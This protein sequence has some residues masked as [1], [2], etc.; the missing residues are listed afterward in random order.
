MLIDKIIE[1]FA[2]K[3]AADR[4]VAREALSNYR[5][6]RFD[7]I[8][9]DVPDF[10]GAAGDWFSESSQDRRRIT[11]RARKLVRRSTLAEHL[12]TSSQNNVIGCG[13]TLQSRS[14]SLTWRDDIEGQW[15]E[16]FDRE[17]DSRGM[18]NGVQIL[19]FV[20]GGFLRDGDIG[21]YL[22]P[23]GTIRLVESD[24][25]ATPTGSTFWHKNKVDGID[26]DDDGRPVRYFV[27]KYS[28]EVTGDRRH[29]SEILEIPA[30]QMLFLA[31]RPRPSNTRGISAYA[32]VAHLLS[33]IEGQVEAITAAARMAA[34]FGLVITREGRFGA[35]AANAGKRPKVNLRPGNFL[36]LFPGES[37]TQ[38]TPH[39][40]STNYSEFLKLLV[41]LV[42][43]PFGL[44]LEIALSDFS[45]TNYSN[46][47]ASMLQA[48]HG[49]TILQDLLRD[50]CTALFYW[51][52]GEW[53]RRGR[54]TR[55]RKRIPKDY[56]EH[57]WMAPRWAWLAPEKEI[58]AAQS[59]IDAGFDTITDVC[60]RL[61]RDVDDIVEIRKREI[62]AFEK[63]GVP[64]MHSTLTRDAIDPADAAEK[65]GD[66]GKEEE[67]VTEKQMNEALEKFRQ[68]IREDM[69]HAAPQVP[70]SINV[71]LPESLTVE[72]PPPVVNV[73]VPEQP[74]PIIN[75]QTA[76]PVVNVHSAEQP[77]PIIN[78]A[79][80]VVHNHVDVPKVEVKVP[81]A[82]KRK[83]KVARDEA[84][85]ISS[86]EIE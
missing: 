19:R 6:G 18:F 65:P 37:V 41:R 13:F 38:I 76:E 63:A 85:N 84:G 82:A 56:L 46:A 61:G 2:P 9:S 86:G 50:Y 8:D 24:E 71:S 23:D 55:D 12:L 17:A 34:C 73:H 29:S 79:A 74:A 47:R 4:A 59:G 10:R 7:P 80:P 22:R 31:R 49:W 1:Y 21:T 15:K 43:L 67:D 70:P 45:D 28:R 30:N 11:D 54:L 72:Q 44:P 78:V 39:Q 52:M 51:K 14:S 83:F 48:W 3:W 36:E 53:I 16:W 75:V 77:A 33:Q 35:G 57:R 26:L 42:A 62:E 5:G 25:I 64:L 32:N 20:L 68:S 40:P 27:T 81:A 69:R 60:G 58:Q 66:P